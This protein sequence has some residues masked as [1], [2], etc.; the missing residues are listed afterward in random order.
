MNSISLLSSHFDHLAFHWTQ[1]DYGVSW[2][3]FFI[4]LLANMTF[5]TWGVVQFWL[6]FINSLRMFV[7][8]HWMHA[9]LVDF[10]FSINKHL[11]SGIEI[12]QI[13]NFVSEFQSYTKTWARQC[14]ER[15]RCEKRR[16]HDD[17]PK[18]KKKR[19]IHRRLCVQSNWI[20]LV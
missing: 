14:D 18:A 6:I 15:F 7:S 20:K 19:K 2:L 1:F 9:T 4:F 17:E 13:L 12:K 3:F 8:L 11:L 5:T 10:L 16:R